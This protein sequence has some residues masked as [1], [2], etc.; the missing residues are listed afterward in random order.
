MKIKSFF[1]LAGNISFRIISALKNNLKT[2]MVIIIIRIPNQIACLKVQNLSKVLLFFSFK[3]K[4]FN[5]SPVAC[6]LLP[7]CTA[8]IL[9]YVSAKIKYKV[10]LRAKLTKHFE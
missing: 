7:I 8:K 6:M 10:L 9:T 2:V 4:T 3:N 5:G 1:K